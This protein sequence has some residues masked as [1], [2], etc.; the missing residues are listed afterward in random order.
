MDLNLQ[1]LEGVRTCYLDS[2]FLGGVCSTVGHCRVVGEGEVK[3]DYIVMMGSGGREGKLSH[4]FLSDGCTWAMGSSLPA[5]TFRL[6]SAPK[7]P[8]L[9]SDSEFRWGH[10]VL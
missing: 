10:P 4:V 8:G 1:G 2:H 3:V 5:H 7:M 6:S 9:L